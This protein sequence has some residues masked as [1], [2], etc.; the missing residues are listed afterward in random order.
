VNF[1]WLHLLGTGTVSLIDM[2]S[3]TRE[4]KNVTAFPPTMGA[5]SIPFQHR[6]RVRG[7]GDKRGTGLAL[8]GV[9]TCL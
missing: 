8:T 5:V 1:S 7:T 4:T 6:Y 3:N 9:L 2:N